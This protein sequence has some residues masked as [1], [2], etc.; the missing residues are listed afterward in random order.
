MLRIRVS[1]IASKVSRLQEDWLIDL[2]NCEDDNN[3]L[4]SKLE[5]FKK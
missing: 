4:S 2:G 1:D 5:D 3:P